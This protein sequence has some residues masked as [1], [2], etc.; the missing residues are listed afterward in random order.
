MIGNHTSERRGKAIANTTSH[1]F[2][3]LYL[4][5]SY[6]TKIRPYDQVYRIEVELA[7]VKHQN[8]K[9][10]NKQYMCLIAR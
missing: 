6:Q 4:M 10:M 3:F 9:R 8:I 7:V 1:T 5:Q 2:D